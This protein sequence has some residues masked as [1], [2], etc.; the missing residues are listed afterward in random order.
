[1]FFRYWLFNILSI[2]GAIGVLRSTCT[3]ELACKLNRHRSSKRVVVDI[4]G[5][6][7][8]KGERGPVGESGPVGFPGIAGRKGRDKCSGIRS[9]FF[10]VL[11]ENVTKYSSIESEF[12]R[13]R[14]RFSATGVNYGQNYD[15]NTGSYV[16]P[17]SGI[18]SFHVSISSGQYWCLTYLMKNNESI[19][20]MWVRPPTMSTSSVSVALQ[21]RPGDSIAVDIEHLNNPKFKFI[22]QPIH[23]YTSFGGYLINEL[24]T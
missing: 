14:L 17:V 4:L 24:F 16:A 5:R 12:Q 23:Y 13:Q 19:L 7:G 10:S 20:P 11:T 8:K 2:T 1:M 22:S 9:A 15:Q 6:R 18:Y 3:M 21:L